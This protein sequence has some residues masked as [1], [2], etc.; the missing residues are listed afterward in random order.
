MFKKCGT[1]LACVVFLGG[2][3]LGGGLPQG[4]LAQQITQTAQAGLKRFAYMRFYTPSNHMRREPASQEDQYIRAFALYLVNMYVSVRLYPAGT[5]PLT[6]NFLG[7]LDGFE[8]SY[9]P[10]DFS[11]AT[12]FYE[13]H[14]AQIDALVAQH[15]Q[16]RHYPWE[17][18][19][20]EEIARWVALLQTQPRKY[21]QAVYTFAQPFLMDAPVAPQVAQRLVPLWE[22]AQTKARKQVIIYDEP[23]LH[24][25]D[26]DSHIGNH[27]YRRRRTYRWVSDEC[28][29]SS[30]LTAQVLTQAMSAERNAWG[31][32]HLYML[33]AYPKNGEFLTPA[34]GP[35]F[36]LA[37][38]QEG[39]RWRYH[40][41][42]LVIMEQN[43]HYFP[44][45][46]DTFLGGSTPVSLGQWL[47]HFSPQTEF[48]AVPFM[49][50]ETTQNAL[51][52]PQRLD[53]NSVWVDGHKY[54]PAPV[55]Q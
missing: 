53:G 44:V 55:L 3:A 6:L 19:S 38:G 7:V 10:F 45:V 40:T 51:K 43:R 42:V 8:R 37:N 5:A 41:A 27:T 52:I 20:A 26:F 22:Q 33:T 36:K 16:A 12:R 25:E 14:Q 50:D 15:L 2:A 24:L 1:L 21:Q 54:L 13:K 29:Y 11:R 32:S 35:R 18:P 30:Y 49:A 48:R 28:N 9:K 39:L 17:K 23:D 34:S 4:A 47:Q 46:L 31:F